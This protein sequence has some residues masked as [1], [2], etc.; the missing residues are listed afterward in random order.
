[1]VA[2]AAVLRAGTEA[3]M[4]QMVRESDGSE[5]DTTH[6]IFLTDG[7]NK[8]GREVYWLVKSFFALLH[9]IIFFS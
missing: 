7:I 4:S 5:P 6:R 3:V 8:L 1:M 2:A 9:V